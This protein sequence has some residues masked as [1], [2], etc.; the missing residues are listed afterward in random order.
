M[1]SQIQKHQC[2]K[3]SMSLNAIIDLNP[4]S[5]VLFDQSVYLHVVLTFMVSNTVDEKHPAPGM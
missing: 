3:T 2:P 4:P 5:A 1:Y